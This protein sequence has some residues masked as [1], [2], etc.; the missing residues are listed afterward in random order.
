LNRAELEHVIKAAAD[1][2]GDE[3]VVI[4]S[5]AVLRQFPN[6]PETML[7]SME[8]DLYPRKDPSRA[9]DIDGAI[10]DGSQ[11]HVTYG[12][13]GHGVG[14][15][16]LHAPAGWEVRMLKLELP[17]MRLKGEPVTAWF[18]EVH[19]LAL[20]KLA[21]GREKDIEFV[22]EGLLAGILDPGRLE[23]GIPLMEELDRETTAARLTFV[24]TAVEPRR[25]RSA[26][27]G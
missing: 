5:Q 16:T 27:E 9:I 26:T 8:A 25:K 15:E 13:Y 24:L 20:A 19:D 10:G 18:L 21:A 12:Y 17:P 11:F 2:T 1:I 14:P 6:A 22:T 7:R 4:G 3:I 23:R